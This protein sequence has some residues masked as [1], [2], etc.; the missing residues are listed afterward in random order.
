MAVRRSAEK[1]ERINE[2]RERIMREYP[3]GFVLDETEWLAM[4][5]RRKAIEE[6]YDIEEIREDLL[7]EF[8]E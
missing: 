5:V 3:D 4:D 2:I 8:S 6:G 1:E 7:R